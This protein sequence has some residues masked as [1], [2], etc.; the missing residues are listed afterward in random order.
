MGE[1][2]K[3]PFIEPVNHSANGTR[4]FEDGSFLT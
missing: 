2:K 3:E 4:G 1:N